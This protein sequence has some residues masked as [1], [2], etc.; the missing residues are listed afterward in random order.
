M[1][2]AFRKLCVFI[3][4]YKIVWMKIYFKRQA[5]SSMQSK[6]TASEAANN[7]VSLV[8]SLIVKNVQTKAKYILILLIVGSCYLIAVYISW[9]PHK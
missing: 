4:S 5:A 2:E 7:V 8:D 9:L 6:E 1:E 3:A